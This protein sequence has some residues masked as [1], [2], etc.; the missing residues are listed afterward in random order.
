MR[1]TT[2]H[3]GQNFVLCLTLGHLL[4]LRQVS[5]RH[6]PA[7]LLVEDQIA[8]RYFNCFLFLC[9]R[10]FNL[11]YFRQCLTKGLLGVVKNLLD[12]EVLQVLGG[13]LFNEHLVD[14]KVLLLLLRSCFVLCAK[15]QNNRQVNAALRQ[16]REFVFYAIFL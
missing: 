5:K 11:R 7:L 8:H 1:D 12:T 10:H 2:G 6:H 16:V 9:R 13:F 14:P 3:Q 15:K 4:Y